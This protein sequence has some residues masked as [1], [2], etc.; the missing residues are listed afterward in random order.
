MA[1]QLPLIAEVNHAVDTLGMYR[2]ELARILC[3]K[4]CDVSD[5][6]QL[7]LLL[8]ENPQVSCRA[9]RFTHLYAL[10]DKQFCGDT[11][12]MGRWIPRELCF[13]YYILAGDGRSGQDGRCYCRHS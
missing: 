9:K 13:W 8:E 3:L 5:S 11:A 1:V 4:C 6:M 12:A 7:E 2:V 10:L